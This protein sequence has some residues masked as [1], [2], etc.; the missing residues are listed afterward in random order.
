MFAVRWYMYYHLMY[1]E[2][3]FPK[4]Q[5]TC[6]RCATEDDISGQFLRIWE[7][8]FCIVVAICDLVHAVEAMYGIP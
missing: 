7:I 2:F 5:A 3:L 6:T 4:L 1:L 8:M